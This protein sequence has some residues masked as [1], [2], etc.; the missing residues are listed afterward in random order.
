MA[1]FAAARWED[2]CP[3]AALEWSDVDFDRRLGAC[4]NSL[5]EPTRLRPNVLRVRECFD[6]RALDL[7]QSGELRNRRTNLLHGSRHDTEGLRE[8]MS[9]K[10]IG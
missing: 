8:L 6:S 3:L 7:V 10:R 5:H 1:A 9:A 2:W 4:S